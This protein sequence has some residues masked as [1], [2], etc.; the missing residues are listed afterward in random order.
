[1]SKKQ[2]KALISFKILDK[3]TFYIDL[4]LESTCFLVQ[5]LQNYLL[6]SCLVIGLKFIAQ[7]FNPVLRNE[8]NIGSTAGRKASGPIIYTV[9]FKFIR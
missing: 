5:E 6:V 3:K 4:R 9:T 2:T 1:M 8:K 7:L